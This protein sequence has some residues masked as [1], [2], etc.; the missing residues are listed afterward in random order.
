VKTAPNGAS[1][2]FWVYP[3]SFHAYRIL[4]AACQA[5]GFIVAARPL[6]DGIPIAGSPDGTR[7]AGQ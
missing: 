6:P 4:Q 3:D 1:L 5:E 2:T 7:S